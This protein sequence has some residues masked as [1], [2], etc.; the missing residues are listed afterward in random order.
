M[1]QLYQT[2]TQ[3]LIVGLAILT[4][5]S[6]VD[7]Y[8]KPPTREVTIPIQPTVPEPASLDDHPLLDNPAWQIYRRSQPR[9]FNSG[10][11]PNLDEHH[12]LIHRLSRRP[13]LFDPTPQLVP[14]NKLPT[15]DLYGLG[16]GLE[17]YILPRPPTLPNIN[18]SP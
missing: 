3:A 7:Q 9:L 1:D 15:E 10:P 4:P 17:V 12:I 14:L 18:I 2:I 6:V 11:L 5:K 8:V 13:G 16:G